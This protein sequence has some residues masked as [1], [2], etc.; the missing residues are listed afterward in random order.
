MSILLVRHAHAGDRGRWEQ[1]DRERP[2]SSLGHA[3]AAAIARQLNGH[4]VE[5]VLS[6]PAVRCVE[7]VEPLAADRALEVEEDERLY[8]T[9]P[10]ELVHELL[11]SLE[12]TDVVLCSHGDVIGN[13]ISELQLRGVDVGRTPRWEKGSTWQLEVSRRRVASATYLPAP[14]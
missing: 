5:R 7:T 11:W 13:V 3:Q 8:E 10:T 4:P 6:S 1:E 14:R 2:L 9:T 12:D